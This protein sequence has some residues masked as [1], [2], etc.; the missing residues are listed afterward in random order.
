[1]CVYPCKVLA[2]VVVY[3]LLDGVFVCECVWGKGG[4][5]VIDRMNFGEAAIPESVTFL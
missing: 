4:C 5:L 3:F 1:M 2:V